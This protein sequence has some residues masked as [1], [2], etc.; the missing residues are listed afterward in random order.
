METSSAVLDHLRAP[1]VVQMHDA[2][3]R[4]VGRPTTTTA[5]ILRC[6]HDAKRLDRKHVRPMVTGWRS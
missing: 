4:T 1:E 5:V 2:L 6:F 3:H